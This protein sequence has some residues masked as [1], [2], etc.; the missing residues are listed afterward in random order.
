MGSYFYEKSKMYYKKYKKGQLVCKISAVIKDGDKY[1][2]LV[3]QGKRACLIGG[4]VEDGETNEQAVA[5][6]V[7][8]EC[9]GKV[10]KMKF[11]KKY[12]YTVEW[13]FKGKKFPNNRV[14]DYYLCEI[15][16]G[17]LSAQG[18]E[19]EFTC[20][21]TLKWCDIKQLEQLNLNTDELQ[22]VKQIEE[23]KIT[24]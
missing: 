15:E 14:E 17:E 22:L 20:E 4:S 13:E 21:T 9:G 3:K 1:L 18:L 2:V 12:Y 5:R 11:L 19:G 10:V 7:L 8:E 16:K 23:Q 24:I 6:E